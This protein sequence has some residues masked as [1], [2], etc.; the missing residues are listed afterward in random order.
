MDPLDETPEF[1]KPEEIPLVVPDRPS[2]LCTALTKAGEP[3]GFVKALGAEFCVPHNPAITKE[4]RQEW[5][6]RR[7]NPPAIRHKRHIKTREDLLEI[8]SVRFDKYLEKFGDMVSSDVEQTMC[9]MARTYIAVLKTEV[10]GDAK[11][12]PGWRMKGVS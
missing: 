6:K 5:R 10:S 11:A 2:H 12:I 3:C 9:D 7:V 1:G 8:L 4:Q